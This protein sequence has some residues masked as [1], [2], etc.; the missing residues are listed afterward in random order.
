MASSDILSTDKDT[1]FPLQ[2][3]LGYDLAQNLFI[4]ADN[5]IVE[6]TSDYTYLRVIS[7]YLKSKKDRMFLD[8]R[9]SIIP[10]GGADFVPTFVALLGTK[11][12]MTVLVDSQKKGHQRLA[13][14]ATNGYLAE[15]RI[16]T[17]GQIL[18]KKLADIEDLF[19][20]EDYLLL[21]NKALNLQ[22]C[23][24]NENA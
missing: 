19:A 10:V 14:L 4:A 24:G 16:I 15:K 1:I 20:P 21:Y 17:I 12:D 9:W 6:G 8:D 11:L 13:H 5:L 7:D 23:K 2:G 3:A 18:K 22:I